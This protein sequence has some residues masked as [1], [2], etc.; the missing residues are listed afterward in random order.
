MGG[1]VALKEYA[2]KRKL[3]EV[4]P[5]MHVPTTVMYSPKSISMEQGIL[6]KLTVVQ[7]VQRFSSFM[8]FDY[9]LSNAGYEKF[10][11]FRN[12]IFY[13]QKYSYF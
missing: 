3:A 12:V 7:V 2:I 4:K 5:C 8:E 11:I 1:N 10:T 6:K 13:S 9:S